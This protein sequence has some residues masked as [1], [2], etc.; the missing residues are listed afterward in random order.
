MVFARVGGFAQAMVAVCLLVSSA[1][2]GDS[3]AASE[4]DAGPPGTFSEIYDTFFPARTEARCEFCHSM[5]P[6]DVSNGFL[7][8][9]HD[10]D[11]AYKA[12]IN[13]QS[14]G[15]Q[16]KAKMIVVPFH[17]ESSLLLDKLNEK[18]SCGSRMPL[19]GAAFTADQRE[20]VRSWIAA[21]AKND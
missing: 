7:S 5:P 4:V 10:K 14:A 13:V 21:G 2:G 12:L 6:S 1:C 18:P 19:G 9:G 8:T 17:P 16:C 15:S 11:A 3:G 20:L